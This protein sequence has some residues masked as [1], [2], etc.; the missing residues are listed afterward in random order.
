MR[1]VSPV[2]PLPSE[3]SLVLFL[4]LLLPF[5]LTLEARDFAGGAGLPSCDAELLEGIVSNSKKKPPD[6]WRGRGWICRRGD[7]FCHHGDGLSQSAC[8][9]FLPPLQLVECREE[10][11]SQ[12]WEEEVTGE[13][14]R[15]KAEL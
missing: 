7:G 14:V 5:E 8:R 13:P 15:R 6:C 10:A 4:L 11:R 3:L 1:R 12:V 2:G 9:F